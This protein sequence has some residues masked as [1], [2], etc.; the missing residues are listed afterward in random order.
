M[1]MRWEWL[2]A[3]FKAG[4][5]TQLRI[6]QF[7]TAQDSVQFASIFWHWVTQERAKTREYQRQKC[8]FVDFP[9]H[10][11]IVIQFPAPSPVPSH[12]PRIDGNIFFSEIESSITWLRIEL[13]AGKRAVNMSMSWLWNF[14][15]FCWFIE[16]F[17]FRCWSC[18]LRY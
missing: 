9:L 15:L 17:I 13:C 3:T 1:R 4:N 18:Y 16:T 10:V 11:G 7:T 2:I 5:L 12:H 14:S 6:F 8:N